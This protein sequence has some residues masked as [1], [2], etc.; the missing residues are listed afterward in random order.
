MLLNN[1]NEISQ[2]FSGDDGNDKGL[3]YMK[4]ILLLQ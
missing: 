1:V 4:Y 3:N 2:N